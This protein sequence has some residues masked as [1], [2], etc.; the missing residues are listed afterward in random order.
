M[1]NV[2]FINSKITFLL[3]CIAILGCDRDISD[4]AVEAGFPQ[5]GDIFIDGFSAGLDYFPFGDSFFEA[6]TVDTETTYDGS[7]AAMRF[8]VPNVGDPDGAYSGAIFRTASGRDLSDFDALTFWAKG[9]EAR[10]INDIGFG[11]DFGENKFQAQIS[12]TIQ[13]TTNWK[14]YIIPIPDPSKL[15]QERGMLW[16]AEGPENGTGFSFW[17]DEVKFEKLGTVAQPRPAILNGED[18]VQQ[19]FIGASASVTGLTETFNLAS[20]QDVTVIAAPSYFVFSSSNPSVA[21]IDELGVITI[22]SA[23]TTIITATLDGVDAEGS[24]TLISLGD[25]T[26]APIPTQD[27]A[28][29]ISI[30]S[31]TYTNVPVDFYNGFWEP[32]QTTLSDDF[33]VNGDNVL[34]YTDFNFVGTSFSNPT[35][36]ASE[37]SFAHFDVFIPET[38]DPGTQLKITIRDFGNDGVEGG[39]DDSDM[40]TTLVSSDLTEGAWSSFDVSLT[41]ANKN[42]LG[43]IIYENNGTNFTNFYLDNVYFWGVP[44]SPGNAA[45]TPTDPAANVISMFSDAYTNVTVDTWRTDWSAAATVFEDVM[46]DGQ[47][48]KK[49]T[50]LGFVGIETTSA[51][52]D[53]S[54]MTHFHLDIWS[55]DVTTFNVKLVDF[56]PDDAFGGGDD[57][58]YEISIANP[59]QGEWVSLDIP[60]TDFIGLTGQSNLAQYILVGQ[61]FE[62]TDV[63]IDNMYFHN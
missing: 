37:M 10:T 58:E 16:Y 7:A 31:D 26:Q 62:V 55:P 47:A 56:G 63:F 32:Y 19:S 60:L 14:K 39:G 59:N 46:V 8:D 12:G 35:V 49:Y 3:A 41:I 43:L 53:A 48:A 38:L 44:T 24:L 52:I 23:G 17:F 9:S 25:F 30:F 36:N 11:Q 33:V 45:P 6:F 54:S 21:T 22:I 4:D 42:N 28:N 40:S 18:L 15:T 5:N 50:D 1:K 61:P 20:G 57:S 51:T 29:V 27:S 13:L 2:N 34:N